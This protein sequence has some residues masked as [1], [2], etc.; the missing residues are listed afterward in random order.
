MNKI[1]A[2][3]FVILLGFAGAGFAAGACFAIENCWGPTVKDR[4]PDSDDSGACKDSVRYVDA[5]AEVTCPHRLQRIRM[6]P[7]GSGPAHDIVFCEC[8][9]DAAPMSS[10][11]PPKDGGPQ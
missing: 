7:N 8:P 3:L 11:T 5:P 9:H 2:L 4:I 1:D 6:T 10:T